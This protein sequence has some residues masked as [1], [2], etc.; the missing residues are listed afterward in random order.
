MSFWINAPAAT[1]LF[2]KIVESNGQQWSNRN[3][4]FTTGAAGWQQITLLFSNP[5]FTVDAYSPAGDGDTVLDT[6]IIKT[7]QFQFDN[8]GAKTIYIDDVVFAGMP[9]P[10][11]TFTA[12]RTPTSSRTPSVS[13]TP[14]NSITLTTTPVDTVTRTNTP[15]FTLTYT[16]T[17]TKTYT[18]T[19]TPTFTFM[20]V[21]DTHNHGVS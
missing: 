15:T 1:G 11:V 20:R 13:V 3:A 9:I 5:Q 6:N 4:A 12:T 14:V 21:C 18:P 2:V 19:I 16:L 8:P 17:E 10:S 7:V